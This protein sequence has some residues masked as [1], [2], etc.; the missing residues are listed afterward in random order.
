MSEDKSKDAPVLSLAEILS[1]DDT[2]YAELYVE[3]LGG[4]VR[5]RSLSAKETIEFNDA[6]E[7]KSTAKR[8][9]LRIMALCLVNP[10]NTPMFPEMKGM[11]RLEKINVRAMM[12]ISDACLEHNDLLTPF[13]I[14]MNTDKAKAKE[15]AEKLV[16]ERV[17][18]AKNDSSGEE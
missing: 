17:E 12:K 1:A 11:E 6:L 16:R 7:Q 13:Q 15:E 9:L 3:E 18:R 2:K 10:D 8:V 5:I 14:R 4:K